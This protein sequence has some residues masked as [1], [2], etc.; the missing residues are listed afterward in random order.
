MGGA[1]GRRFH[2]L[3]RSTARLLLADNAHP[4]V[5]QELLGHSQIAMTM[6]IYSHLMPGL[7]EQATD[8][9]AWRLAT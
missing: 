7:R 9:L 6:D 2:D 3:R 5:V 1:S 8:G 4:K